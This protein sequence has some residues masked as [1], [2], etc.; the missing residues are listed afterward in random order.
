MFQSELGSQQVTIDSL[1]SL[2]HQLYNTTDDSASL[3]EQL[4]DINEQWVTVCTHSVH[5]QRQL[6]EAMLVRIFF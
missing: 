4:H 3:K 1:N 5:K 6:E 2:A